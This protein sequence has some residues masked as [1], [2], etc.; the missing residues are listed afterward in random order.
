MSAAPAPPGAATDDGEQDPPVTIH[1]WREIAYIVGFYGIYTLVR[2]QFGSASVGAQH[3]YQ[4]ALHVIDVERALGLFHEAT[5]QGW[6][7]DDPLVLRGFNIFYGS[8]HFI[9]TAGALVWL[10]WRHP[11]AYPVWRNTLLIGTAVALVGFS[12]FPLMPPRLL[13]DCPYGAGPAVHAE[14]LPAF[15]DTLAVHDGLWS[16]DDSTMQA[17]SNQYAAMPS[18]HFGWALWCALVIVPRARHRWAKALAALYPVL[19]LLAIIVTGNHFW[20]DA[21]G[22]ALV[23]GVGWLLGSRL[24]ALTRNRA[25]RADTVAAAPSGPGDTPSPTPSTGPDHPPPRTGKEAA[26]P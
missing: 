19:T 16:F 26:A 7:L 6:F 23:M 8:L 20:L 2:N 11:R 10:A 5:I 18:L 1:W 17:V 14:D 9:V 22:G 21:A 13:C 4:N 3:A 24:A 25:R 15:V 12:L